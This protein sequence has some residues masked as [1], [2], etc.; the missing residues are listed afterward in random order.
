MNNDS[1]MKTAN[2]NCGIGINGYRFP[3]TIVYGGEK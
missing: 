2:T 3:S 1:D